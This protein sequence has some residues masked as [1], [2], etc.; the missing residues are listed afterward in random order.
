MLKKI[1]ILICFAPLLLSF[2]YRQTDCYGAFS[3]AWGDAEIAHDM[4][5]I[6]CS[7]VFAHSISMREANMAFNNSTNWGLY[8]FTY[9]YD[10]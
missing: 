9:T 8:Y 2:F 10:I 1:L 4:H 5:I 6:R 7:Y 3:S